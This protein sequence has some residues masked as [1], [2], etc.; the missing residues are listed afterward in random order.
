MKTEQ[1]NIRIKPELAAA[2]DRMASAE[3]I[4]RA[5]AARRLL[6]RSLRQWQ[7]ERAVREYQEGASSLAHAAETAGVTQWELLDLVRDAGVAHPLTAREAE[8]RIADLLAEGEEETLPDVPPRPG[9]VLL[10]GIHPAPVSVRAGHYYQGRLGRRLWS[11][12]E[13]IGLLADATEGS[14]DDEFARAGNGLTDIV[15]RPTRS[16]A[17][18]DAREIE[19]GAARLLEQIREWRPGLILFAFKEPAARMCGSAVQPGRCGEIEGIP[20]FL[21]TGPYAAADET[22]RVNDELRRL[23]GGRRRDRQP[24]ESTQ[25]ITAN[26]LAHGQIRLPRAAKRFFPSERTTLDVVIKGTR[27]RATYDPRL[28]PDRARSA[29]LRI[30]SRLRDLVTVDSTM[31]VSSGPA[32][33]PVLN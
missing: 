19:A 23:L 22:E 13:R 14:E 15:K 11:R 3:S 31:S 5:A 2:L 7:V 18:L 4:D 1:V 20:A 33:V 6:E 26:D 12:L 10:V 29:V 27:V 32:G 30:G 17:E 25:R 16:A 28:G 21:L 9:G 8:K 24:R